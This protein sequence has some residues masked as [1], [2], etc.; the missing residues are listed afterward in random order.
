MTVWT[1]FHTTE[2]RNSDF[3]A[4]DYKFRLYTITWRWIV[5][6][7]Y[8]HNIHRLISVEHTQEKIILEATLQH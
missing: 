4:D 3:I 2:V 8:K 7:K 6:Q 5:Y 1:L